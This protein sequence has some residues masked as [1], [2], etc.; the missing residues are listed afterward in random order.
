MDYAD[1]CVLVPT[2]NEA[3][4]IAEVVADYR[5]EGFGNVLVVDGDSTDRTRELAEEAG[6]RVVVQSGDGKGQAV[7]EA[8]EKHVETKYVLMLD[9][10]GTYEPTDAPKMLEPLG[11]GYEHVIGDRF[12]DMRSGAMTTLN[13]IGNQIIN[14]AFALIHGQD[15]GDILSGYRAFTRESFL[16]M[17]LTSDGFGIETE[18]AVECAKRGIETTV[19]PTTYY[20]RPDGSDTNLHPIRDGGIIFLELYRRAKTNN[21]LFYF[22]SVGL[23]STATG[24]GLAAYVA[25]E[26]VVRTVSHEVIA[27]VS[28]AGILFGVQ[29]L[30]FG[31]LSDLILSLHREQMKRIQDLEGESSDD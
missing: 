27:V 31:V 6:A 1:V 18:M 21:P 20:P 13:R 14:R 24:L 29:L 10:D 4:T 16:Q 5:D 28:A 25:Y 8:V 15:F 3:E 26:W 30:M 11:E 2:Y 17:T 12:A 22:G 19:V 23:A 7:R 9:G